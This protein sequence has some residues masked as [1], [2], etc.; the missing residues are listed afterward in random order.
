MTRYAVVNHYGPLALFKY[1]GDAEDY[2]ER[3]Y[4][5]AGDCYFAWVTETPRPVE[6]GGISRGGARQRDGGIC[7]AARGVRAPA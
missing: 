7:R 2:R 5:A 4:E 3:A 6:G 1:E